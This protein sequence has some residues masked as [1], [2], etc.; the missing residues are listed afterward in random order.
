LSPL[1]ELL[2]GAVLPGRGA[3]ANI[4][5]QSMPSATVGGRWRL[6]RLAKEQCR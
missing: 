6:P 4:R 5:G 1:E 2:V 3:R